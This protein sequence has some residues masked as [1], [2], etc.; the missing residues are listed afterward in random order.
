MKLRVFTISLIF[1]A[2]IG[3][4]PVQGDEQTNNGQGL[5][6]TPQKAVDQAITYTGFDESGQQQLDQIAE[7][8]ILFDNAGRYFY[9]EENK[10]NIA[11]LISRIICDTI[12]TDYSIPFFHNK[13][14]DCKVSILEM[15]SIILPLKHYNIDFVNKNKWNCK[16]YYDYVNKSPIKIEC[17]SVD[18]IIDS[19]IMPPLTW[20]EFER[21]GSLFMG[22]P[23]MAPKI[24]FIDALDNM[25]PGS[26]LSSTEICGV[27]TLYKNKNAGDSIFPVWYITIKGMPPREI[28]APDTG[29][30]DAILRWHEAYNIINAYNGSYLDGRAMAK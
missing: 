29:R 6:D 16:F 23:N 22:Y 20:S 2:C 21:D 3:Y 8:T 27:Y 15:D 10:A 9:G 28:Y 24:S 17:F 13:I 26:P 1:V 14:K 12:I 4:P 25:M 11:E 19:T 18:R 30:L 7:K 5:I